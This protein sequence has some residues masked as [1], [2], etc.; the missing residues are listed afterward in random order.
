MPS[1]IASLFDDPAVLVAPLLLV[2]AALGGFDTIVN[3]EWRARLPASP[4]TAPELRLHAA[5]SLLYGVMF[6]LLAAGDWTGAWAAL[7]LAISILEL[8]VTARDTVVETW[9]RPIDAGERLV[10]LALLVNAGAYTLALVLSV[11]LQTAAA[12]PRPG[13]V[14]AVLATGLALASAGAIVSGVRDALAAV[15]RERLDCAREAVVVGADEG[16]LR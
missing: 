9:V 7:L 10:H 8:A 2:Q 4:G 13:A 3:H 6:A 16:A 11:G 14:G 5:R 15:R 1:A 12:R